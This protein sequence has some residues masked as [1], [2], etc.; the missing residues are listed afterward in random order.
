MKNENET[1]EQQALRLM[2][3]SMEAQRRRMAL[4]RQA[5]E[6]MTDDLRRIIAAA[7]G[8][9]S[10]RRSQRDLA[11]LVHRVWLTGAISDELGRPAEQKWLADRAFT[12]VGLPVPR[13]VASVVWDACHRPER[14]ML[15]SCYERL[16]SE[17]D[18]SHEPSR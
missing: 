18:A 5:V 17:E 15:L 9:I 7:P 14:I 4:E 12:A 10:W 16:L 6:C 11:E 1:E 3:Q 2:R 8:T 13:R